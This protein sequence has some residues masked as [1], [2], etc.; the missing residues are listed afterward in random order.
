[1]A[2]L[3]EAVDV[4]LLPEH[5]L[6]SDVLLEAVFLEDVPDA[7]VMLK[8]CEKTARLRIPGARNVR[9]ARCTLDDQGTAML[10]SAIHCLSGFSA[11]AGEAGPAGEDQEECPSYSVFDDDEF[12][13]VVNDAVPQRSL[14]DFVEGIGEGVDGA[15]TMLSNSMLNTLA[16]V[17]CSG[18]SAQSW[19]A[20]WPQLPPGLSDLDLS[21]N[22]LGDHAVDALCGALRGHGRL[23]RRLVLR[24]N[25]CKN[26]EGLCGLAAISG[27]EELD[28]S[29]NILNNKSA[30]QLSEVLPSSASTLWRLILSNNRR[31]SSAG[32][33]LLGGVLPRS[34]LRHLALDGTSLC[35]E[36]AEAFASVLPNCCVN[37]IQIEA[38]M[39]SD[40]GIQRLLT[41]A[42]SKPAFCEL[43]FD[44]EQFRCTH[45]VQCATPGDVLLAFNLQ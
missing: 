20:L 15:A 25:R 4:K 38:A 37:H 9:V 40:R 10:G 36:G 13:S 33:S 29:G 22:E 44:D 8:C 19:S 7:H 45:W 31:L 39:V 28:L 35:D 21:G 12:A 34:K 42:Q 5:G 18:P 17:D 23:P 3:S 14:G 6:F 2:E 16:I 11:H 27:L 30:V 43:A 1:M 41:A 24:N 32:L 26:I